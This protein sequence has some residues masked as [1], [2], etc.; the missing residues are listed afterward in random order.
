MYK[1]TTENHTVDTEAYPLL[2][3][4]M[5]VKDG[6]KLLVE[7][8]HQARPWVDEIVIAD[9][10]SHDGITEAASQLGVRVIPVVW[11]NNSS[12]ALNTVF[13]QCSARWI[14]TLQAHDEISQ[15][16]WQ[17]LR[18]WVR[19]K[20]HQRST[21]EDR[22][23]S[24]DN[25]PD[26]FAT[27][28]AL[29]ENPAWNQLHLKWAR[30]WAEANPHTPGAWA[31]LAHCAEVCNLKGEALAALDRAL[32]LEPGNL[33][34]RLFA[35]SLLMKTGLLEQANLQLNAVAGSSGIS[36]RQLAES[37]HLRARIALQQDQ[38]QRVSQL[39][40][41][42]IRLCPDNG[43]LFKTLGNWHEKEGRAEA[44]LSAHKK[45]ESL[46]A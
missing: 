34:W 9:N 40:G 7:L 42:A 19:D 13:E 46:L 35:G 6:G 39:L 41:L 44:A 2:C 25:L 36:D 30:K 33:S 12:N 1:K 26:C 20:Y 3:L 38:P 27:P 45:A 37:C 10:G 16:D 17:K 14:L 4:V 22:V 29:Q 43:H 15:N 24:R 18:S 32:V 21:P 11:D 28:A 5:I 31:E 23:E 8:L